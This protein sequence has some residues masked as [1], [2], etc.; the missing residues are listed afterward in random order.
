MLDVCHSD[1]RVCFAG[2]KLL[3]CIFDRTDIEEDDS[4]DEEIEFHLLIAL[5]ELVFQFFAPF[6]YHIKDGSNASKPRLS[7]TAAFQKL[8]ESVKKL[9]PLIEVGM[10]GIDDPVA[11]PQRFSLLMHVTQVFE[12]VE[13]GLLADEAGT[14]LKLYK[15]RAANSVVLALLIRALLI[16][17]HAHDQPDH[18]AVRER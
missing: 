16:G 13:A 15:V 8:S 17:Y 12:Q 10:Y 18:E 3:F 14:V 4:Y 6:A 2:I 1:A 5:T 9:W 7:A 11:S